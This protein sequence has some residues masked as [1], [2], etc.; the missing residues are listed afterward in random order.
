MSLFEKFSAQ[1]GAVTFGGQTYALTDQATETNRMF[2]GWFGDAAEGEEYIQEWSAAGIDS[3]E[4][5][6]VVRWQF[7]QIKGQETQED[8]LDWEAVHEVIFA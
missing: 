7:A 4:N 8:E 1:F 2:P 3:D 5:E 6:V